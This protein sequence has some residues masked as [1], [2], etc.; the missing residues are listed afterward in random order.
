MKIDKLVYGGETYGRDDEDDDDYD[1]IYRKCIFFYKITKL[2]E[3]GG[4]PKNWI[5][6]VQRKKRSQMH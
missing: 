3:S 2:I 6:H 1:A 4:L 5:V